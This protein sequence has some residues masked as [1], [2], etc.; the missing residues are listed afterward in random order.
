MKVS[1]QYSRLNTEE[2]QG[3]PQETNEDVLE[4]VKKLGSALDMKINEEMIDA[5][6]RLRKRTDGKPAGIVVKFV[7]RRDKH[8]LLQKRRVKRML[9][10]AQIGYSTT[11]P[12]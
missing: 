10:T 1:K 5:C 7:R 9:N 4:V 8:M 6:H 12:V 3:I 11:S 2:I